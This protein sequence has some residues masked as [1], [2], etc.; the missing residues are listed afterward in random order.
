MKAIITNFNDVDPAH[1]CEPLNS[2]SLPPQHHQFQPNSKVSHFQ[3]DIK[4]LFTFLLLSPEV[5]Q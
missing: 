3:V 2:T 4:Y 5:E 1:L